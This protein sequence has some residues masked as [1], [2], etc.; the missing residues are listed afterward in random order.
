V[1]LKLIAEGF[2]NKEIA[3]HLYISPKTVDRHR[4]NVMQKLNLH[5]VSELTS[6]AIENGLVS[7]EK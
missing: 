2:K 3:A 7:L 5:T 1:V 6:F 4:S